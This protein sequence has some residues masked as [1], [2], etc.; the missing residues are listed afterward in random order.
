MNYTRLILCGGVLLVFF[1][2]CTKEDGKI[3]P[4]PP[5]DSTGVTHKGADSTEPVGSY[6]PDS[7]GTVWTYKVAW[8]YDFEVSPLQEFFPS[9]APLFKGKDLDTTFVY[10]IQALNDSVAIGGR[11][12]HRF[13]SDYLQGLYSPM[14]AISKGVY[15]AVC[16]IWEVNTGS[17]TVFLGYTP[18]LDTL[19]LLKEDTTSTTWVQTTIVQ[20]GFGDSDTTVYHYTILGTGLTRMV[21]QVKYGNVIEVETTSMP[22][23]Y[24]PYAS[25][26]STSS[27]PLYT[28]IDCYYAMNIGLIE[29]DLSEALTGIS[30]TV[31]LMSVNIK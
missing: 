23:A 22:N 13:S 3:R 11:Q 31:E 30:L 28:T 8:V 27:Y 18:S 24:Q 26:F 16:Q 19:T 2:S 4:Y 21:N 9:Y 12:Y 6:Q 7:A 15:N 10:H 14:V 25:L 17:G 29:E 1:A 20:D 5:T